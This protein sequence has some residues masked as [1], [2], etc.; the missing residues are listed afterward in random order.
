MSRRFVT[1]ESAVASLVTKHG[2]IRAAERA[3]GI[4]KSFLGRVA[5]GKR[6]WPSEAIL[7]ALGLGTTP[8]YE[9]Q[10]KDK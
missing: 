8:M 2:G 4:D 9:V 6:V 10:P 3:T 7:G 1:V 5:S